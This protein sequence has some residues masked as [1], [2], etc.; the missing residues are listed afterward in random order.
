ME[1]ELYPFELEIAARFSVGGTLT[2]SPKSEWIRGYLLYFGEGY[3]Y[4]MWKEY[5][6]F[7]RYLG[8][9]PGSYALFVRHIWLLKKLGLIEPVR[10]EVRPG[11]MPR[12]YYRVKPGMEMSPLWRRPMQIL[13][14]STDWSRPETKS[15]Y[16]EKYR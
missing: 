1:R 6:V 16:R 9:R 12:V 11:G 10:A 7:A 14:P 4:G 3:P 8:I 15:V 5:Q 13:Y 2:A